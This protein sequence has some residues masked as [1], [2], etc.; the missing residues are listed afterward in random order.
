QLMRPGV[1]PSL[2]QRW[3]ASVRT[4]DVEQLRRFPA[5]K[6]YALAAAF[7]D[8]ARKRLLDSG[9]E[10]HAQF[11]TEMQREARHTWE[12]DHRQV[13]QRRHRGVTSLRE[14]AETVLAL[15]TSPDAPLS[16]LLAH[17]DPKQI[18]GAV[19]DCIEFER[20]ERHGLL[21][22]LPSKDGNF[23]PEL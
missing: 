17:I 22:K 20:R 23:P 16:T 15:R 5:D 11:M 7:L 2:L 8:D 12:E 1:S 6:R 14:L 4:Y 18:E 9:V 10:M 19:E 3:S 21:D 13:R